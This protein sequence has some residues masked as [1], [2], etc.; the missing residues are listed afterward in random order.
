[1]RQ[2]DQVLRRATGT[3]TRRG[4]L[5]LDDLKKLVSLRLDPDVLERLKATGPGWQTR[6]NAALRKAV[7]R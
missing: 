7:G 1:M 3:F 6:A 4:R 2:G 5:K